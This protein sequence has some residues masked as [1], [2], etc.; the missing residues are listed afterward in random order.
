MIY[1]YI[2]NPPDYSGIC[3]YMIRNMQNGKVY[4]GSTVNA[5]QRIAQ[6]EYSFQRGTCNTKFDLDIEKGDKFEC[7]ILEKYSHIARYELR[8]REA[9]YV[10]MFDSFETGYNNMPVITYDP[11]YYSGNQETLDWLME[12]L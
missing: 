9:H 11:F 3:V 2:Q 1:K 8:D 12:V 4:V 5:R 7:V 10:R 6:H